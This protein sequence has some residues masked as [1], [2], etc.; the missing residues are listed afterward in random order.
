M[1]KM[2][3]LLM[4][5]MMSVTSVMASNKKAC[6][7]EK[8]SAQ[9]VFKQTISFEDD[10]EVVVYYV[11]QSDVYR[12]YSIDDLNK[13]T[14]K[15][16]FGVKSFNVERTDDYQGNCYLTCSTLQEVMKKANE[17]FNKYKEYLP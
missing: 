1:K 5:A 10:S 9:L 17:L 8:D 4:V 3:M 6:D 14:P 12:V 16:L 7:G 11:K 15:K 2:I 13:M